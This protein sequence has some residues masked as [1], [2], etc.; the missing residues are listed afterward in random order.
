VYAFVLILIVFDLNNLYHEALLLVFTKPLGMCRACVPCL[1]AKYN[2]SQFATLAHILYW[3]IPSRG[4]EYCI[5]GIQ[6][7]GVRRKKKKK[8]KKKWFFKKKK[9][10]KKKKKM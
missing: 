10:K 6:T 2:R 8:K 5:R 9:K 1:C 4:N 7:L 3:Y